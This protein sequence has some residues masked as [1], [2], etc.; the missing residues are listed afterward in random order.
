M[1]TLFKDIR[2]GI[3]NL[4]KRPGLTSIIVVTLA[5]GIGATTAIFSVVNA[6]LLRPLPFLDSQR[7]VSVANVNLRQGDLI[8]FNT[9]PDFADWHVQSQSFERLAGFNTRDLT[10]TGAGAP[11]RRRRS[12]TPPEAVGAARAGRT[13]AARSARRRRRRA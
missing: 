8:F 13:R 1:E 11:V 6:V 12:M 9:W 2:Y 10:L 7:L 3:R 4:M 5:L